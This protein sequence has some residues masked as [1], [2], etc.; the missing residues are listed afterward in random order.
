VSGIVIANLAAG[1]G[2]LAVLVDATLDVKSG[3][4]TCVLGES[5]CGKTTLL[6]VIAGF[7]PARAGTVR[8]GDRVLDDGRKR[9]PAERRRVGYVPQ[10]GALFPHLTVAGNVGFGLRRASRRTRAERAARVAELLA[11]VGMEGLDARYPH[12]LS[13]GQQQRVAVA[14][15]LAVDP[16][17]VLL[18]E[19][20]AALDASLRERVRNDIR[21]VLLAAGVTALLVTHDRVE[22]LS[23]ADEVA[24]MRDG[25]IAQVAAPRELYTR[26]VSREIAQFVAG[27]TVVDARIEGATASSPLGPLEV[28]P[29]SPIAEGAARAVILPEQIQVRAGDQG[30]VVGRVIRAEYFGYG[31]RLEISVP[32]E[33]SEIRLDARVSS[34][35][36]PAEGSVVSVAITGPVWFLGGNE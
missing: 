35:D 10:E 28:A 19:P 17:I 25:R 3:S 20:F 26:P 18:D 36:V 27:A 7:E 8:I 24:V 23:I 2:S 32:H 31:A 22:A 30:G 15:A 33:G 21:A 1:Y 16:E 14:R 5:G 4:L 13:G 34:D 11:L 9:V 6:R 29:G 12:Q